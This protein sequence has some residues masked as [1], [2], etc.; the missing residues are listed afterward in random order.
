MGVSGLFYRSRLLSI[1]SLSPDLTKTKVSRCGKNCSK[2]G[3]LCIYACN[4][5][6][7]RILRNMYLHL[8]GLSEHTLYLCVH[9]V[10]CVCSKTWTERERISA[11]FFTVKP[12]HA[13][14]PTI[15][16]LV[17]LYVYPTVSIATDVC[18]I[19]FFFFFHFSPASL[20]KMARTW[21]CRHHKAANHPACARMF[22]HGRRALVRIPTWGRASLAARPILASFFLLFRKKMRV[23]RWR[24]A[25]LSRWPPRWV[26]GNEES[27]VSRVERFYV[28]KEGV[29]L[30]W[31]GYFSFFH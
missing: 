25:Q 4:S 11:F 16:G 1:T 20:V 27:K 8:Q 19:F 10:D 6:W 17:G 29:C 13:P 26:D 2:E 22:S 9:L 18:L 28:S 31:W 21:L 30:W 24:E 14:Q 23:V 3:E 12:P 7:I 5:D 15:L